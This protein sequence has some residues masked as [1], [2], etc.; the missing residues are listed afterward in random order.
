[1]PAYV[2]KKLNGRFA[3]YRVKLDGTLATELVYANQQVDVDNVVRARR[4]SRVIGVTFA[5][6]QRRIVYF[7]NDYQ[8]LARALGRAIPNLPLIDFGSESADGQK[9]LIHAGSDT[10]AG[11][12]YVFD[13]TT[14]GL[15]EILMA[16]PQLENRPGANVRAVTYPAADGARCRPI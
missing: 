2:L 4:G 6:E 13:R 14:R 8:G 15:N 3:L 5:D 10:D 9:I 1:M 16:R 12:Y 11:R 7:D